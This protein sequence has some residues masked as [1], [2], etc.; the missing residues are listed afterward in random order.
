MQVRD[1]FYNVYNVKEDYMTNGI[2]ILVDTV[3][4]TLTIV[5]PTKQFPWREY[6]GSNEKTYYEYAPADARRTADCMETGGS[7]F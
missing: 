7:D 4:V 5:D 2:S 6:K 3:C 1:E